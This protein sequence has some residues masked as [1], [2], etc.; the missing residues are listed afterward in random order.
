M[1]ISLAKINVHFAALERSSLI[2]QMNST[3]LSHWESLVD[4]H[5]AVAIVLVA[6]RIV[7][8]VMEWGYQRT[9]SE[10]G[11]VRVCPGYFVCEGISMYCDHGGCDS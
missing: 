5:M 10:E 3:M 6:V 7:F 11:K 9:I 1:P 8:G 4:W 2:Q